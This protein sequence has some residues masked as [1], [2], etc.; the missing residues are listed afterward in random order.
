M[1]IKELIKYRLHNQQI[2]QHVFDKPGDLIKWLGAIQAQDYLNSLWAIGLRLKNATE[3]DI[4]K[5]IADKTIVRTWPMRRT[6]HFVSPLDVRWLLKLLTPRIIARSGTLYKQ[7]GFDE[8][9][10]SKCKKLFVKTLQGGKQLT[11]NELY[12]IL[13]KAKISTDAQRGL[14]ILCHFAQE[15]LI[16]FAARKGKQPTFTLLD[17][18]IPT[19]TTLTY[20]EAL[21]ELAKR[22]FT[23]HGPATIQDFAWW[24][25]LTV[26]ES[27]KAV[28]MV[29]SY[30]NKEVIDGQVYYMRNNA[31]PVKSKSQA[32]YLLPNFDEY[33]VAYKD[34]T[35][36]LDAKY[37]KQVIGAAGNGIFSPVIVL[38]G[39]VVATWK[40]TIKKDNVSV[41]INP[42]LQLSE[43][44]QN[45]I[46]TTIK[47]YGKFLKM[48]SIAGE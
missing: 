44:Q 2:T 21:A 35:A 31:L 15:G 27:K 42:F 3:S 43:K 33:L 16:C 18:W 32:I 47:S 34:R 20:D 24:S 26:T 5:A 46:N 37:A 40:R 30:F 48:N 13:E 23:S 19:T 8:K 45:S 25:G 39:K 6:L 14:H 41:Q 29:S 11:R 12:G 38:N 4:E 7:L 22:Y 1:T 28:E 10:L 9:L 17:E 36:A